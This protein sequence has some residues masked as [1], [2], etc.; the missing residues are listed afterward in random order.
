[1]I[2][3]AAPWLFMHTLSAE[4]DARAES[5]G[6]ENS[7]RGMLES[8]R[9]QRQRWYIGCHGGDCAICPGRLAVVDQQVSATIDCNEH[10]SRPGGQLPHNALGADSV[11]AQ[12]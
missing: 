10:Q 5:H 8:K 7:C 3:A 1:M 6:Q 2:G 11:L 4:A 9:R 12:A